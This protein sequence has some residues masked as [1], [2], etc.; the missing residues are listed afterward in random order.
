M[1]DLL[2][3]ILTRFLFLTGKNVDFLIIGA[4]KAATTSLH[5]PIIRTIRVQL[6]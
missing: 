2:K 3:K 1:R 4:Q 5:A 6:L